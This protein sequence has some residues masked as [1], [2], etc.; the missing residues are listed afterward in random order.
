MSAG[1]ERAART[2][3]ASKQILDAET[4]SR[5]K[6]TAR[7]KALRLQKE[8]ADVAAEAANPTVAKPARKRAAK[9]TG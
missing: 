3:H 1:E 9:K 4:A 5:E 6:K 7:L 2:N 8:A